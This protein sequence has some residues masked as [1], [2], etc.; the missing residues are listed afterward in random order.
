MLKNLVPLDLPRPDLKLARKK[1]QPLVWDRLRKKY[2]VLTPEEWVRQHWIYFLAEAKK[3]PWTSMAVEG[4]FQLYQQTQRSDILVYKRQKPFLL[5]ECKAPQ[6]KIDQKT[7]DQANRYNVSLGCSLIVLSNG[8]QH[9]VLQF[10]REKQ[11]WG[12]SSHLPAFADW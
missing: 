11:S 5:V 7:L 12:P 1:D 9:W 10:D 2:L 8:L 6:V 4:G 3:V